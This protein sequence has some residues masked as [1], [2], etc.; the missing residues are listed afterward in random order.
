ML[1]K[2]VKILSGHTY[3]VRYQGKT[4]K[5]QYYRDYGVHIENDH[6]WRHARLKGKRK[7]GGY[8]VREDRSSV[9]PSWLY[10]SRGDIVGLKT[11]IVTASCLYL[12]IYK[13]RDWIEGHSM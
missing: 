1:V 12:L 4:V 8:K 10:F 3:T 13:T 2:S 11:T 9:L 7:C 6:K 5:G